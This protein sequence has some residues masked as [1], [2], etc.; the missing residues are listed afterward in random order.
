MGVVS[1]LSD[2]GLK[3][4][5]VGV[6]KA[7]ILKINPCVQIVDICHQISPQDILE[8]AFILRNSFRFFPK[9]TV[10]L[11][12]I[13]PG[14]GTERKKIIVKTKNFFF[15]APD[16]G[17]LSLSLEIEPPLKIIEITEDNYFLKPVSNSFQARDI[18]AP[19]VGY[20][21]KGEP[22]E[23]FGRR[24]N[25][26]KSL[27][28]PK[29]ILRNK[30]LEGKIIY[31]DHFGNLITNIE[32]KRFFDFVKSKKFRI[33]IGNFTIEKLFKSYKEASFKE[34]IALINSFD[35]LE[36]AFRNKDA[37][38]ILK[39]KKFDKVIIELI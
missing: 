27:A 7:V 35:C 12:V 1:F 6:V 28:L 25:S 33:R 16:N 10:H 26:Y 38:K 22:I 17:I 20:L 13:D 31:V 19:V 14:V 29:V 32:S 3:D 4:N 15:V 37:S 9:G 11:V 18:F 36:I 21:S 34:P 8:G 30:S 5:F 24:I 39:S 2:F 23:K